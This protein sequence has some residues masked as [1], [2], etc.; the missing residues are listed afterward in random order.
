MFAIV[1]ILFPSFC[2]PDNP[3]LIRQI[4]SRHCCYLFILTPELRNYCE[5]GVQPKPTSSCLSLLRLRIPTVWIVSVGLR[6]LL[7]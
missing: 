4:I 7:T 1:S 3:L 5:V 2:P 6:K